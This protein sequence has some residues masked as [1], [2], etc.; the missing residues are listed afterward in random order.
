MTWKGRV[1]S[2]HIDK[3]WRRGGV[4][5]VLISALYV[6]KGKTSCEYHLLLKCQNI[7]CPGMLQNRPVN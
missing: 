3:G 4:A 1:F 2:D 6:E 5:P 7:L